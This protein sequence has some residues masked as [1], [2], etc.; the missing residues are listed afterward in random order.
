MLPLAGS[1]VPGTGDELAADLLDRFHA[2]AECD[3]T[4][5]LSREFL[6]ERG[7]FSESQ[8]EEFCARAP[9]RGADCDCELVI[10]VISGIQPGI[11]CDTRAGDE[12]GSV[13]RFPAGVFRQR[14]GSDD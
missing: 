11:L 2:G 1:V 12:V 7:G 3:G 8:I 5:R 10:N 6:R 4:F 14:V 13:V 9:A